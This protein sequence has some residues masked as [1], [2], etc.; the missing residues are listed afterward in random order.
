MKRDP[1]P[2]VDTP[3]IGELERF[4]T[5]LIEAG[6]KPQDG[7]R[8]L[9]IGPV[10]PAFVAM[11]PATSM[12]ISVRDG[13]PYLHPYIFVEGLVGARH[14][15]PDGN[16]CLW[17]E[18]EEA[19]EEWLSLSAIRTRIAAWCAD[20]AGGARD[21]ALDAHL[22]F[23]PRNDARLVVF[24]LEHLQAEGAVQ[25][26]DGAH[27]DLR[28]TLS[29]NVFRVGTP[30]NLAVA[31]YHRAALP[32]PPASS[33]AF[34][35]ALTLGQRR[36]FSKFI[37]RLRR[38]QPSIA[39][40]MWDE[41][42]A[43]NALAIQ[44]NEV[45]AGMFNAVAIQ[46]GRTDASV[47]RLRAGPDAADIAEM[48]VGVVGLGAIG[49]EIAVT[50]AC[51]GV[52]RLSLVDLDLLRP[53]NLT[54]HAA[55]GRYVGMP[56]VDAVARSI[57]DARLHVRVESVRARLWAPTEIAALVD[58]CDLVVD[59]T[60]NRS[61]ADLVSRIAESRGRP[62]LTSALYRGGAI[63]RISVQAG[64]S[65]PIWLRGPASGFRTVPADPHGPAEPQ[66]ETGCGA[67]VNN[68]PP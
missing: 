18:G 9:W 43:T 8:H 52:G 61:Y 4:T 58:A 45:A 33:S 23:K 7:D 29:S 40:L 32:S 30:G 53:G 24:D 37:S 27:A 12:L 19:Y 17:D 38:S 44:L 3:H 48:Q 55:S 21:L 67:P 1:S 51:C 35:K 47:M 5:E 50:L 16:V 31:W 15:N 13:W 36:H 57:D 14:V 49:S 34:A 25:S 65:C 68:A 66:Q 22:Y 2:D 46:V 60:G 56:K 59:S 28:A 41:G 64:T 42:A 6:F 39:I 20:Q 10:D 62:M 54:R 63:A 11:T 26:L